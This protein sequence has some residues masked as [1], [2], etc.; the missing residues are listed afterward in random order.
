[1]TTH[2]HLKFSTVT[3][4]MPDIGPLLKLRDHLCHFACRINVT[5]ACLLQA[6][7]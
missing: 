7:I 3:A 5:S 6:K 1:M 4:F 2:T